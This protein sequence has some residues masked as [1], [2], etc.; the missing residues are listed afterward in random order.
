M[1]S[2]FWEEFARRKGRE[3]GG[4]TVQRESHEAPGAVLQRVPGEY[5]ARVQCAV[6]LSTAQG[7]L[8]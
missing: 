4:K 7:D 3:G 8:T 2:Q 6:V 5:F 1:F